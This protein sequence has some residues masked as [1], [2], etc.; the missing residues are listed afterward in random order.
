MNYFSIKILPFGMREQLVVTLF[1]VPPDYV[2]MKLQ[3]LVAHNPTETK[4]IDAN[5]ATQLQFFFDKA[6]NF[7]QELVKLAL[8]RTGWAYC[9]DVFQNYKDAEE[10]WECDKQ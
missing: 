5:Q 3:Q 1:P 8:H 6:R 10:C 4:R 7:K 2:I 9:Q